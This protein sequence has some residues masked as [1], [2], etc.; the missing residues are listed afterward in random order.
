MVLESLVGGPWT[1]EVAARWD[2]VLDVLGRGEMPPEEEEQPT[3]A[4]RAAMVQWIRESLEERGRQHAGDPVMPTAR[5]LTSV[6]YENT[7]RDLIGFRLDL[8]NALPKDPVA[9]YRFNNTPDMMR[10]GPEQIDRY[11]ECSRRVMASAIVEAEDPEVH[12][13]RQE[14]QPTGVDQ[15]LGQDEIEIQTTRRNSPG[16]GIQATTVPPTGEFRIRFQASAILPQGVTEMPLR[17]V[18]GE[19]L[20]ENSS[21]LQTAP[22]GTVRLTSQEPLVF[23]LRGRIENMPGRFI[24]PQN[25]HDDGGLNDENKFL[26]WPRRLSMPRAVV[27]WIEFECPVAEPW[28]P[29][30]HTRILFDSPPRESDP[31]VYLRAVLERF[32]SRAY[33]RPATADEIERFVAVYEIARPGCESF[34]AAMRETLAMV[35]VS[36]PFLY[37]TVSDSRTARQ[38]EFAS[39]LS[40]FLW[41]SMPDA[42]LM[43]LAAKGLLDDH[44]VITKQVHRLLA[45]ERS[46]DFVRN[47]TVQWLSLAKMKTVPINRELFPRFLFDVPAGERAGTEEP[48]RPTIRDH[49]LD[50]TVGFVGEIIRRNAPVSGLVDADFVFI[51]EPLAAHY[52]VE[53]VEGHELRPVPIRREHHIGG[54]LTQGSVLIGNGTG[55]APHPIYRAVWL[56]EAILGEDVPSPPAEVP[57]LAD[58]AGESAEKAVTIKDL[59]ARHRQVESCN[60]CHIR[61]DPWGIPFEQ[62]NAVGRHQPLVPAEG[63][64]VRGFSREEDADFAGY[65]KY[66]ASINTVD[67][68]AEARVPLG[69]NINGMQQLK[70]YLLHHRRDAIGENMTRRLLAYSIGRD[71]TYR[72]RF[73]VERICRYLENDGYRLRDMII[74]VCK[75]DTFRGPLGKNDEP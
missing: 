69:P 8:I 29:E 48:N 54:L 24:T 58:P 21:T 1:E 13:T 23:E 60:E 6:E 32:L 65:T 57:A 44:A 22:V 50:E 66:L 30:H 38:F 63:I 67:L 41:A 25:L 61:L 18:M 14:W 47:F 49:M 34:E 46:S 55:S 35:L 19:S 53:G 28:P 15:G 2:R 4:E 27:N 42:E 72:D 37:H 68:K 52:G 20:N 39:K 40:Y 74:S 36:P 9:P 75:S 33:R 64:R 56:R 31:P 59:L 45:D 71:L 5:R 43:E 26:Y 73:A 7:M 70:D 62:Y 11:L 17:I 16:Q 12:T 51:N 10:M 3:A